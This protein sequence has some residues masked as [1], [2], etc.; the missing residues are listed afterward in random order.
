MSKH[1][2]LCG[3]LTRLLADHYALNLQA[4][5]LLW[6]FSDQGHLSPMEDIR[7]DYVNIDRAIDLL[8]LRMVEHGCEFPTGMSAFAELSSLDHLSSSGTRHEGLEKLRTCHRLVLDDIELLETV[9]GLTQGDTDSA[10]L[11][12]LSSRHRNCMNSLDVLIA[13]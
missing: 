10:L 12:L 8:G 11:N 13:V 4:R 3:G 5:M 1:G 9:L 6:M 7:A 2:M